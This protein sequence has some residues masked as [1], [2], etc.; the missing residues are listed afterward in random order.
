[1]RSR[2]FR[3][4]I[5]VQ[6][7]RDAKVRQSDGRITPVRVGRSSHATRAVHTGSMLKHGYVIT[8]LALL[9]GKRGIISNRDILDH[10]RDSKH[11]AAAII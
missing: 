1:M 8:L 4:A 10:F 6:T 5:R 3:A 9:A 2:S 7:M 11:A